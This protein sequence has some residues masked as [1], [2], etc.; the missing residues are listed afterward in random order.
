MKENVLKLNCDA[1]FR[2]DGVVGLRAIVLKSKGEVMLALANGYEGPENVKIPEALA[3]CKGIKAALI[4]VGLWSFTIES[5]CLSVINKLKKDVI[6]DTEVGLILQDIKSLLP[7]VGEKNFHVNRECNRVAHVIAK[8]P[9]S[10]ICSV[11]WL[12]VG[13]L[14]KD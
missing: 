8:W 10:Q 12:E 3:I 4:D 1:A 2:K 5:D 14:C 9:G 11:F 6:T 13:F 7:S